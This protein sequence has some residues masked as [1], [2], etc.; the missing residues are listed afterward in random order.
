MLCYYWYVA[1]VSTY[2]DLKTNNVAAIAQEVDHST[3][4]LP[5]GEM[6]QDSHEHIPEGEKPEDSS[7][8]GIVSF[9]NIL[10]ISFFH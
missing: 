3:P 5:E 2:D 4:Q 10:L 9:F 6:P 7:S 8:E 1:H